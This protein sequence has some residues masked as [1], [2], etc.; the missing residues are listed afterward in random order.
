MIEIKGLWKKYRSSPFQLYVDELKLLDGEIVGI[1][2]ANGSG[3]SSLLKAIVGLGELEEGYIA[4]DG[5]PPAV[6]YTDL[7]FITEEGSYRP[8]LTSVEYAQFLA[9]YYPRFDMDYFEH[10]LELYGVLKHEKIRTFS[11]GQKAKLEIAAGLAK[12]TKHVVMDEPFIGKDF[13]S[14]RDLFKILVSEMK[15]DEVILLS[16]HHIADIEHVIDRAIVIYNGSVKVDVYMDDLREEGK[17]LSEVT[18]AWI[19]SL[20]R[21]GL[22]GESTEESRYFRGN[23]DR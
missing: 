21:R 5:L 10:L 22:F 7:A 11:R 14:R 16:T 4:I 1:L 13:L 19:Q 6:R 17:S 9:D 2:G 20:K 23:G 15:G 18:E 8:E 12:R 3:K